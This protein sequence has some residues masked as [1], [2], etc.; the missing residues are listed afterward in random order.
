MSTRIC[1]NNPYTVHMYL[2]MSFREVSKPESS[3]YQNIA[4]PTIS[5]KKKLYYFI[6]EIGNLPNFNLPNS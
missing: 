3:V 6:S 1:K 5:V 4:I 2:Y